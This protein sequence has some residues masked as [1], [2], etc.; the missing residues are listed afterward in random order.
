MHPT[1]NEGAVGENIKRST[2]FRKRRKLLNLITMS[3]FKDVSVSLYVF[4]HDKSTCDT[5][6]KPKMVIFVY[7]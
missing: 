4:L 6:L 2:S 7:F 3:D 1:Y 5:F